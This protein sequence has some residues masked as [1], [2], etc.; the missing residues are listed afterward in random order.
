MFLAVSAATLRDHVPLSPINDI[1]LSKSY[2]AL[3]L[4]LERG[5]LPDDETLKQLTEERGS[6]VSRMSVAS[7]QWPAEPLRTVL[8]S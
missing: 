1:N 4:A 2:F 8:I 7:L 6:L 5:L 3:Q